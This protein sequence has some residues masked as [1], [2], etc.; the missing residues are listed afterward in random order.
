MK[1]IS[2]FLIVVFIFSACSQQKKS[3]VEYKIDGKT[4]EQKIPV[5]KLIW[6][7]EG[8][9]EKLK[10]HEALS[11]CENL[12]KHGKAD[13]RLPAVKELVTLADYSEDEPAIDKTVFPMADDES[14]GYWSSTI[15]AGSLNND[16][17]AIDFDSGSVQ[18]V[19]KNRHDFYVRCVRDVP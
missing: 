12:T 1:K 18:S 14:L 7:L 5:A 16:A 2:I 6:E 17:W 3:V 8:S 19:R 9:N 15:K 4:V 10:W 11:Y 13:W